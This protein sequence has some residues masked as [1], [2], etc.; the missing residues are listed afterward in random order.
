MEIEQ[1]ARAD[2]AAQAVRDRLP[3]RRPA[4]TFAFE[5]NS[6]QYR[7]TVEARALRISNSGTL[8]PKACSN[9]PPPTKGLA[10][11]RRSLAHAF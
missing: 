11:P 2:K 5:R 9:A 4:I 10:S 3:N 6:S 8:S 1:P 7:A